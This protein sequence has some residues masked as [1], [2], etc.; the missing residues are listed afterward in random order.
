MTRSLLAPAIAFTPGECSCSP[1]GCICSASDHA[2]VSLAATVA[3]LRADDAERA[4]DHAEA[5][6]QRA[7]Q[8]R[9]S[10]QIVA[11]LA[12][13]P[14]RRDMSSTDR[15]GLIIE[16]GELLTELGHKPSLGEALD[17]QSDAY[18]IARRDSLRAIAVKQRAAAS[19]RADQLVRQDANGVYRF[20]SVPTPADLAAAHERIRWSAVPVADRDAVA[21]R[22]A[23]RAAWV[24]T[25]D[26]YIAQAAR[27]RVDGL[28]AAQRVPTDA[29][30][31]RARSELGTAASETAVT[32][33][34]GQLAT[35][36]ITSEHREM[37]LRDCSPPPAMPR[38]PA[39]PQPAPVRK[40]GTATALWPPMK[41]RK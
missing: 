39:Q 36:R 31:S 24:R 10:A 5:I 6:R 33:R 19:A 34:A 28:D 9:L 2:E 18:L 23:D 41:E 25:R 38:V 12:L 20:D 40:R 14:A 13:Q 1:R 26:T 16:I 8:R 30:R 17:K 15:P 22:I 11:A 27:E 7:I 29:D 3:K 32:R 21:K 37:L 35:V 4:G